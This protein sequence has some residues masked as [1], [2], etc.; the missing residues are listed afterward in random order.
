M[1]ILV[2]YIKAILVICSAG[3]TFIELAP[4]VEFSLSLIAI[5]ILADSLKGSTEEISEKL[6]DNVGGLLLAFMGN[7]PEILISM[8]A[9]NKG[10]TSVVKA[11][12]S[13]AIIGNLLFGLGLAI[14]AGGLHSS[15]LTFNRRVARVQ[16]SMVILASCG[17]L[18]PALFHI[19][20]ERE[21]ETLS[22]Q[23]SF[24]LITMY[25]LSLVFTLIT[26]EKLFSISTNDLNRNQPNDEDKTDS[27]LKSIESESTPQNPKLHHNVP[28]WKSVVKLAIAA[29]LLGLVSEVVTD[30]LGPISKEFGFTDVFMGVILLS[31]A[32]N[33]GEYLNAISFARA[34]KIDLT[35]QATMGSATQVS[36]LVAPVL[37]FGSHYMQKPMN[38]NFTLYEVCA[39]LMA[40][41]VTRTFTYDGESHWLEGSLLIGIY[42]ILGLGFFHLTG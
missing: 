5:F 20:N 1:H 12:I 32:G 16:S 3:L 28:I 35:I 15:L 36:L 22:L 29:V 2:Y 18:I 23:I 34:G 39:V 37:V 40:A 38:L 11:S 30:A 24:V 13:G 10:L 33:V 19:S 8:M 41:S 6:G 26:H 31:L 27:S 4:I 21:V 9:L 42:I 25:V 17:L 7:L 14:V